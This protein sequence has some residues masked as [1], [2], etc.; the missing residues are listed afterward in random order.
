MRKRWTEAESEQLRQ[1]YPT[2]LGKDLAKMFN[3]EVAQVYNRA[4]K[5]GLNKDKEWLNDYYKKNYKGYERTQF[6]Q[7]MKAWN[8]GMKGLQIGGKETQFKKGQP[9][10]IYALTF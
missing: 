9:P 10:Q 6:Q 7:G 3:C 2:T 1:L 8:K 5:L 4:N